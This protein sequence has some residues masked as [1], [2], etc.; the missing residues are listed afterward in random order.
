M[1]ILRMIQRQNECGGC[2]YQDDIRDL[3]V[4]SISNVSPITSKCTRE[5][6]TDFC[7]SFEKNFKVGLGSN[8]LLMGVRVQ[9]SHVLTP[10]F[11]S[12]DCFQLIL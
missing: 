1:T 9:D 3:A 7:R 10:E 12:L 4:L 5:S 2:T 6:R 8:R 11:F